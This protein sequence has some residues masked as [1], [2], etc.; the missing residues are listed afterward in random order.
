MPVFY[1][2]EYEIK[3]KLF[4]QFINQDLS[5]TKL[6]TPMP[7]KKALNKIQKFP[8][9]TRQQNEI[10]AKTGLGRFGQIEL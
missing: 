8:T 2:R 6:K 1:A 7:N 4:Q 5:E 10:S 9:L 3:N